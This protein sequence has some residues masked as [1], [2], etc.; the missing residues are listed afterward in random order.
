MISLESS[1]VSLVTLVRN[2]TKLWM[3]STQFFRAT[4]LNWFLIFIICSF[5]SGV[6]LWLDSEEG[7]I[8]SKLICNL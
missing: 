4:G 5:V 3:Y 8:I 6:R 1:V 7:T 2:L